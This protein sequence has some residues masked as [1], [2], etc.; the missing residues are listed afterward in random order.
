[1]IVLALPRGG[2]PVAY[3]VALAL[4]AQLDVLIVRKLGLPGQQELAIGAIASGGIRILNRDIIDTLSISQAVIDQLTEQE[5]A[6]LQRREKQY[7]GNR[8]SLEVE[9]R[10]VILIDDGLATGASMLAAVHGLRTKYP[11]EIVAA[12][13]AGPPEA[14]DLLRKEVDEIYYVI[15]PVWFEGVGKWYED[16]SQTTD[17]EVRNLLQMASNQQP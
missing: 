9:N 8:P 15:S 6:E 12:V 4:K 11:A 1:V 16:F 5:S 3:E 2:V 7:R 17:E 10:T 13:P 14:I